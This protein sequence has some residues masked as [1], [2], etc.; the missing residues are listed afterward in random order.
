ML[1]STSKWCPSSS[2]PDI[3][4]KVMLNRLRKEA[5]IHTNNKQLI[6]DINEAF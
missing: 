4:V 6:R 2:V 3:K 5:D 1:R